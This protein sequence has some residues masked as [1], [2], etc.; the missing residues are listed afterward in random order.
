M[1]LTALELLRLLLE[2]ALLL[3][4]PRVLGEMARRLKQ[5]QVIGEL[6]TGIVIRPSMLGSLFPGTYQTVV[7]AQGAQ[8][9]LLQLIFQL[10]VIFLLLL[11]GLENKVNIVRRFTRAALVISASGVIVS[12]RGT[13]SGGTPKL[14]I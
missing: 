8:G 5:P 3:A 1:S 9:L 7:S 11:S 14:L 13:A 2:L 10:V 6:L 4:M 12:F